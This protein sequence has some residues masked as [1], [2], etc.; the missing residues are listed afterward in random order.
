MQPVSTI[1]LVLCATNL[2]T[3]LPA[4]PG[5]AIGSFTECSYMIPWQMEKP[6]Y[7]WIWTCK[8]E[9]VSWQFSDQTHQ[10]CLHQVPIEQTENRY[11]TG[12]REWPICFSNRPRRTE[13]IGKQPANF[14]FRK[15]R[16]SHVTIPDDDQ[17]D[18]LVVAGKYSRR[19]R[20]R[21]RLN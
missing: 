17:G 20:N 7:K 14:F 6:G 3:S 11:V 5:A 4:I 13:I 16:M 2:G 1:L 21:P 8:K 19:D 9:C 10:E 18:W 15:F 12:A